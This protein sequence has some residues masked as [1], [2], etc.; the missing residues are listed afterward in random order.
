[1]T[2]FDGTVDNRWRPDL[3]SSQ[4][5]VREE[6]EEDVQV[7]YSRE[8]SFV[9]ARRVAL[10]AHDAQTTALIR[11][12]LELER[13]P[14]GSEISDFF[15]RWTWLDRMQGPQEKQAYLEKHIAAVR[16]DPTRNEHRLIISG[17]GRRRRRRARRSC[18]RHVVLRQERRAVKAAPCA[19][20]R[21]R[22]V[23]R[24]RG[25]RSC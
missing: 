11:R 13:L 4:R 3:A 21:R 5:R 24:P 23:R 19:A 18:R 25:H 10:E 1:V 2:K 17:G 8:L 12:A 7:V 9:P 20:G 14:H 15:S 16:R 6:E 22:G